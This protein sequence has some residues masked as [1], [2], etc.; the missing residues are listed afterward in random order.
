MTTIALKQDEVLLV[1]SRG[2]QAQHGLWL[3]ENQSGG[4]RGRQIDTVRQLSALTGHPHLRVVY[5]TAG[6]GQEGT[7][8]AWRIDKDGEATLSAKSSRGAEPCHLVVDPSGRLLIATNYTSSTLALQRLGADGSFEG[9][10][11]LVKLSGGGPETERQDDAH[12]HQVFFIGETLIVIDLGAD[13]VREF[14]VDL[15]RSGPD[16]IE[17]TGITKVPAGSGPRHG[18]VLRDGRLAISGELGENLLIGH[19][20][21]AVD[22]WANV[23][24]TRLNGPAKTRWARNYPGDIRRSDDGRYVYFANRSY[25]TIST[26][27]VSGPLPTL[28]NEIDTTVDWPQHILVRAQHLVIAGWDSSRVAAM[29]LRDGVPHGVTDLFECQG[30]G[31]LHAHQLGQNSLGTRA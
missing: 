1:A 13:L 27:D 30:A 22:Q 21:R 7:L 6:I 20:G 11:D 4:W 18:V 14:R 19:V 25:N 17:E 8:H 9:P 28:V 5:G 10:V 26:F 12:P 31:W 29:P 23:R 3:W 24:S 16:T 15:D 2:E